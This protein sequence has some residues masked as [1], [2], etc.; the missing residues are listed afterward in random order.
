MKP[1]FQSLELFAAVLLAAGVAR[2]EEAVVSRY[3]LRSKGLTV[4]HVET[5]RTSER[6][7]GVDYVRCRVHTKVNVNLL[8]LAV[9]KETTEESLAGPDG[10]VAYRR[11]SVED[12]RTTEIAG[13]LR[14]GVFAFTIAQDGASREWR[15]PRS[16][17]DR[18][19]M[20]GF[21]L[22]VPED[23]APAT[24]RILSLGEAELVDRAY[25][26]VGREDV[27]AG[28]ERLACRV[29]SLRD[30]R[31]TMKRWVLRDELGLFIA[32]QDGRDP[33]GAYSMRLTEVVRRPADAAAAASAVRH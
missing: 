26:W 11:T 15:V 6:R 16:D 33:A 29:V 30:A 21:E 18:T 8:F 13:A 7:D 28:A 25:A 3:E 22:D 5:V 32:R 9:H 31:K 4:G 10:V 17:Y 12:G 14:D 1:F 20:D 27:R 23:G 24:L 2:G 19:S